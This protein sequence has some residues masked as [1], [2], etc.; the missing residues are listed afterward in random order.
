MVVVLW[1]LNCTA[2]KQ[3]DDEQIEPILSLAP[4]ANREEVSQDIGCS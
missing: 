2:D 1:L 4:Y 3:P